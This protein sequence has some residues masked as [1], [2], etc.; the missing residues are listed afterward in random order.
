MT[1]DVPVLDGVHHLK[2][3]VTDLLRSAEWYEWVLGYRP[4]VEFVEQ[5]KLAGVGM[6]HPAGGPDFALRLDPERAGAAAGFDYFSIGVPT[7]AD[8]RALAARLDRL[9]LTHGGV[10]R[11][12]VG[13]IL[14]M[15]RDPDGHEVRFYTTDVHEDAVPPGQRRRI[16]DPGPDMWVEVV[17]EGTPVNAGA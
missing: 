6:E 2:L 5:G 15:L 3:P 11:T 7:E 4:V 12:T 14:P 9:G 16:H 10:H 8:V 17:P 1:S 13:W